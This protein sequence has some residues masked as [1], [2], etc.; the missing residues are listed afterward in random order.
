VVND[1]GDDDRTM[2]AGLY[3]RARRFAAFVA[4][5]GIDPDDLVQEALARAIAQG[6]LAERDAPLTYLRVTMLNLVRNE[7]RRRGREERAIDREQVTA[8]RAEDPAAEVS[9]HRAVLD[10]LEALPPA[11]RA[12][13]FLVD[14]EGWS[15]ND[16]AALVGLSSVATRAR[17]SRARRLLRAQI[18]PTREE[19]TS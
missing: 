6:P 1:T 2:F 10:A 13:V 4:P 9:A 5:A 7:A 3:P 19:L 15:V 16:A 11:A 12:A 17:L 14:V 18:A 8:R